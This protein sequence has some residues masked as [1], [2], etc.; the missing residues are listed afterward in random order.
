[1]LYILGY[2]KADDESCVSSMPALKELP[3]MQPSSLPLHLLT[4]TFMIASCTDAARHSA[5]R[6]L[7]IYYIWLAYLRC[8]LQV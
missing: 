1:M 7:S 5:R 2:G 4:F 6:V 8:A 3:G